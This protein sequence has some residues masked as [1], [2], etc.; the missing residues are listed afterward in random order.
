MAKR[1]Y[2]K[3][4]KEARREAI[5]TVAAGL[6]RKGRGELPSAASIAAGAGLA[7]GTVYL[8]FRT[9]EAIFAALLLRGWGEV[10]DVLETVFAD[11]ADQEGDPV[12]AFLNAYVAHLG[13]HPELLR[14]D[15]QRG[16]LERNLGSPD[17]IDFKTAFLARLHSGGECIERALGL[18]PGRG[19]QL[20]LRTHALTVGLWQSMSTDSAILPDAGAAETF[21]HDFAAEL[22]E[23]LAEYWRG[24]LA[25]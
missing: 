8:Y 21:P 10:V 23:A 17:L 16:M 25:A 9:K 6:F 2:G 13:A 1:A 7:K 18:T 15:A 24:A 14:L 12:D 11:H 3:E 22:S 19:V 5:L 4:D 20:L